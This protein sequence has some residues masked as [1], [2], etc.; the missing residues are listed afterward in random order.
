MAVFRF[1]SLLSYLQPQTH[2]PLQKDHACHQGVHDQC[3]PIRV[4]AYEFILLANEARMKALK[5]CSLVNHAQKLY[6]SFLLFLLVYNS[7]L[8][9]RIA[10]NKCADLFVAPRIK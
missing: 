2:A 3:I 8:I 7:I 4:T 1:H 10:D 6:S 9:N 5:I